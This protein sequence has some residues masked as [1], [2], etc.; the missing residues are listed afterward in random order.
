M[1]NT[2]IIL[3][4]GCGTRLRPHLASHLPKGALP[5]QDTPIIETSIQTLLA[6]GI[7]TIY[8]G[9]GHGSDWYDA[10]S[11]QY[12]G[13]HCI[14]NPD[15]ATSGS[16]HTLAAIIP[17]INGPILLLESD[18]IYEKR[19]ISYLYD[20]PEPNSILATPYYGYG[21]EVF[22]TVNPQDYLVS[23]SKK[24]DGDPQL[25][26]VLSGISKCS[27][28]LLHRMATCYQTHATRMVDY[29]T[30]LTESS[31]HIPIRIL[32]NPEIHV[33][34]V[35]TPD[36]YN[37]A[38]SLYPD[39]KVRNRCH[40][41]ERRYLLNP[42]PATLSKAVQY[43]QI[44][45]DICP[46][47]T[48][49]TGVVS[50]IKQH[51]QT[52]ASHQSDEVT[53]TLFSG[54]GTAS[55]ESMLSSVIR[56][57]DHVLIINQGAYGERMIQIATIHGLPH[58]VFSPPPFTAIPYT[59]L[60]NLLSQGRFT[61]LALVH[62]ETTTGLLNDLGPISALAQHYQL[63]VCLDA[64]SSFGAAPLD[65]MTDT[66][67]FCAASSNKNI[68][69]TAGIGMVISQKAALAALANGPKR[70]LYLD[71]YSNAHYQIHQFQFT[72]PVHTLYALREALRELMTEGVSNRYARYQNAW[73]QLHTH[74]TTLGFD[75]I[76]DSQ[77]HGGLITAYRVPPNSR[78]SFEDF[79]DYLYRRHITI[80]PG[81]L[82]E[83]A[84]FRMATIGDLTPTD[85]THICNE[86]TTYFQKNPL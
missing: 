10:L 85:I 18:L 56:D 65:M 69:G 16:M 80:Y 13:I 3:A 22:I 58:T 59:A 81:K 52:I 60:D 41:H 12:P 33:M 4:A 61:H 74:M 17:Y 34:E 47:E 37:R 50:E 79:H 43:A 28:D 38:L 31:Q 75:S 46:R 68:Q 54:S 55:V 73:Q 26:H 53:V 62:H 49:F 40:H 64:M 19:A 83:H 5:L 71:L 9:T 51:L 57:T 29:E 24:A 1:I 7:T 30:I 32:N 72:P 66:V 25:Q 42:G 82:R 86:I 2:A 77:V 20:Y 44:V 27:L 36:H 45:P 67:H 21:D 6:N 48:E 35:D 78:F 23:M 8:I 39:I 14:K 63:I 70:S 84:T 15:F 11:N 76:V